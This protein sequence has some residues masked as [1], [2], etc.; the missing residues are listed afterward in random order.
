MS[1]EPVGNFL[2]KQDF[3]DSLEDTGQMVV[4]PGGSGSP[5]CI[6]D[7]GELA[8]YYSGDM[9]GIG[10]IYSLYILFGIFLMWLW[11][12]G[13]SGL[14]WGGFV[15]VGIFLCPVIFIYMG[16]L[17]RRDWY[18]QQGHAENCAVRRAVI[19]SLAYGRRGRIFQTSGDAV[20]GRRGKIIR[21]PG[22]AY[23]K[24][25][26]KAHPGAATLWSKSIVRIGTMVVLCLMAALIM[27]G[28]TLW[29]G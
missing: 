16:F 29:L 7:K 26:V 10:L 14:W 23:D 18:V 24:D 6:C 27:V 28:A 19:D 4:D 13:S 11:L 21:T 5:V 12:A 8:R 9:I 1:E 15:V 3:I 17:S 20:Y 22:D 25:Y 2:P